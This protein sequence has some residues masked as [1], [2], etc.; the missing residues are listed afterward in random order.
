[1]K[2]QIGWMTAIEQ[3]FG[4]TGAQINCKMIPVNKGLIEN[5]TACQS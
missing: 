1:M 2:L 4:G 3:H 5:R